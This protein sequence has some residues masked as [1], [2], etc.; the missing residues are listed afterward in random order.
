M[1][2]YIGLV[3]LWAICASAQ[4]PWDTIE[5]KGVVLESGTNL[6]VADAKV[7]LA[8]QSRGS[9]Q[10]E[11]V[12]GA[13]GDFRFEAIRGNAYVV[14]I[15]KDGYAMLYRTEAP[16]PNTFVANGPK[17]LRL[18]VGRATRI[19]GRVEDAETREPVRGLALSVEGWVPGGG[20]ISL[21]RATNVTTDANGRF[22]YSQAYANP[23]LPAYVAH[24]VPASGKKQFM[25]KFDAADV[26]KV[27]MDWEES[28]WPGGG[29]PATAI[30]VSPNGALPGDVGTVRV[31]KVS[32]YRALVSLSEP[33]CRKGEK[34]FVQL[35]L[36][37]NVQVECGQQLLL[38]GLRPGPYTLRFVPSGSNRDAY[39]WG[40]TAFVIQDANAKLSPVLQ[41]GIDLEGQVLAAAGAGKVPAGMRVELQRA[42]GYTEAE[43]PG[44]SIDAQGHFRMTNL[45][46]G[47]W[48]VTIRLVD[49][50]I[51]SELRYAGG[52][53]PLTGSGSD[54]RGHLEWNGGG[55][56]ELS[57]DD[58]PGGAMI[59]VSDGDR[60]ATQASVFLLRWPPSAGGFQREGAAIG[61]TDSDGRYRYSGL[62]S[63]EYRVFAIPRGSVW[64]AALLNRLAS[65]G[66]RVMV[67]RGGR[68]TWG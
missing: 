53:I 17:E 60:A 68:R 16:A 7:T 38:P 1:R 49:R 35:D 57:L 15:A 30:P 20:N 24:V 40:E 46:A 3:G 61:F 54:V 45:P 12:T 44:A 27:D 47:P 26:D 56:L 51:I 59:R 41:R 58:A 8:I 11:T 29:G 28:Y 43:R 67:T 6:P 63:G 65:R 42:N 34:Y 4:E 22:E 31:R 52:P 36:R 33:G 5:V 66:E 48:W 32:Y 23:G 9:A 10:K 2:K 62:P 18:F 19:T 50:F 64:D 25:T 21:Q 14:Q 37:N 39:L 13:A 55:A